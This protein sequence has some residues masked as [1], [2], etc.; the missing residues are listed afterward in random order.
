MSVSTAER[1]A[2]KEM[3][4]GLADTVGDVNTVWINGSHG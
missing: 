2:L 1:A 3:C 4:T